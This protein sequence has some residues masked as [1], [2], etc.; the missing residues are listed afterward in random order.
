LSNIFKATS[1]ND[2][3]YSE[4]SEKNT[5][6]LNLFVD[7]CCLI[8]LESPTKESANIS[9]IDKVKFII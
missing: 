6:D 3:S 5:I 7:A 9:N 2:F 8:S 4:A 1:S